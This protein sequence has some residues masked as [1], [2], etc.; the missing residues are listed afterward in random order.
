MK[1]FKRDKWWE[2]QRFLTAKLEWLDND[3]LLLQKEF[4]SMETYAINI[5]YQ[6]NPARKD[7]DNFVEEYLRL[8]WEYQWK[9]IRI[10]CCNNIQEYI[11]NM[12]H[13]EESMNDKKWEISEIIESIKT[14]PQFHNVLDGKKSSWEQ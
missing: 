8:E 4:N 6:R 7:E 12:D 3:E 5:L 13:A 14:I 11:N 10:F 1:I 9:L 2:V